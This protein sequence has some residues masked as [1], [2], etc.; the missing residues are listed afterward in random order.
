MACAVLADF[1]PMKQKLYLPF[2]CR[3]RQIQSMHIGSKFERAWKTASGGCI[4]RTELT[5][6]TFARYPRIATTDP[7]ENLAASE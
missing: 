4:L 1:H 7:Q 3:H 2:Q 5:I 6:I